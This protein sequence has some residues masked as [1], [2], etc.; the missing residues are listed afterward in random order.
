MKEKDIEGIVEDLLICLDDLSHDVKY[1]K[2]D[3]QNDRTEEAKDNIN[4]LNS[5]MKEI[6]RLYKKWNK[7]K[8]EE[9]DER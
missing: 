4:D 7:L 1:A 8:V 5:K 3:V 6:I 9:L 2:S